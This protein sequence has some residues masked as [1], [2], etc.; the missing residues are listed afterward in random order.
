MMQSYDEA[1][2]LA[3]PPGPPTGSASWKCGSHMAVLM[4]P[5]SITATN[6]R[7]ESRTD[8]RKQSGIMRNKANN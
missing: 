2:S 5:G 4:F 7:A 6:S 8:Q 1:D 3:S